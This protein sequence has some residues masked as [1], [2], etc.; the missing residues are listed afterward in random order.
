M[1]GYREAEDY[2]LNI[3]F[4]TKEKNTLGD[5][6][7]FLGTMDNPHHRLSFVHVAGTNGKGSVCAFLT[8][9]LGEAGWR[10]GTF[11]SPH[12]VNLRERILINGQA[13]GEQTFAQAFGRVKQAVLAGEK[14]GFHHPTFFEYLFLLA[15]EVFDREQ[16]DVVILET[17]LGGRLDV[18]NV[19]PAPLVSVITAIGLD[20][21]RYLGNTVKEIAA[22]KAGIIKTGC[23]VVF[24]DYRQDVSAVIRHRAKQA[25]APAYGVSKNAYRAVRSD[26]GEQW[27][28][29]GDDRIRL[30]FQASYQADNGALALAALRVLAGTGIL[31]KEKYP[32]LQRGLEKTVWP[33]RLE[34]VFPGVY[35]DGAHNVDGMKQFIQEAAALLARRKGKCRLLF[36][37]SADK[38]YRQMLTLLTRA[39][40]FETVGL[41]RT[42]HDRSAAKEQLF[43]VISL[44]GGTGRV[45]SFARAEEGFWHLLEQTTEEDVL[46]VVGSLYLVGQIKAE[47][48]K[49]K[50]RS[51]GAKPMAG[52]PKGGRTSD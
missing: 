23:P 12:L 4:W 18:T 14:A 48:Q 8:Y 37:A 52:G 17:G 30:P 39:V 34:E 31:H 29:F 19:I 1:S 20:H 43:D 33:G 25:G 13:V 7:A 24:A 27:L 38:D 49:Q 47:I 9:A 15:L 36:A 5:V 10:V 44:N 51:K 41:T 46:F 26:A 45:Q 11:V 16:V 32:A 6:D 35:L 2:L 28:Y 22:E 42:N 40:C 50:S 21:T 3:P